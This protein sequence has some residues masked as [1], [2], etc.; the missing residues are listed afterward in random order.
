MRA[1][2]RREFA[3]S[4]EENHGADAPF[5]LAAFWLKKI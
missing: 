1:F 3:T 5:I 2:P 4:D